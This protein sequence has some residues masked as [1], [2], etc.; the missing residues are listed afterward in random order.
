MNPRITDIPLEQRDFE[1]ESGLDWEYFHDQ[2]DVPERWIWLFFG[3]CIGMPLGV[4]ATIA[5][6]L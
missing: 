5:S 1:R 6:K 4:L 3:I 2:P